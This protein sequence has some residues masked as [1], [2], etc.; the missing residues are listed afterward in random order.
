MNDRSHS[1]PADR[2]PHDAAGPGAEVGS[3][4]SPALLE[5]AASLG[6]QAARALALRQRLAMDRRHFSIHHPAAL[7]RW[8]LSLMEKALTQHGPQ[9]RRVMLRD[10]LLVCLLASRGM[11]RRTVTGLRVDQ[12]MRRSEEGWRILLEPEDLKV[13]RTLEYPVP[14]SLNAWIDRYLSCE[15]VEML[16]DQRH[17]FVWTN[18][19]GNPLREAGIEK[20]I[21]W[22]SEKEFGA[23]EAFGPHRFRHCIGTLAPIEDPD[24]P[25]TAGSMLGITAAVHR[26][27]YDRSRRASAAQR[28][29]QGLEAER[30]QTQG[31]AERLFAERKRSED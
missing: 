20:R 19:T 2:T 30:Q 16:G 26:D 29:H 6:R 4:V 24:A 5:L 18:W 17:D 3:D 1:R 27:H 21:R 13:T 15:R 10:G 8:G 7:Y 14:R 25:S 12:H 9:R 31:L 11:R 28:F 22:L 23:K